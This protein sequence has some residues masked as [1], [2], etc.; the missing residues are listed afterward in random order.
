MSESL[1]GE[2][3]ALRKEIKDKFQF[4]KIKLNQRELELS[5]RVDE[6]E[7]D[8]KVRSQRILSDLDKLQRTQKVLQDTLDTEDLAGTQEATLSLISDKIGLLESSY[9][10]LQG[11]LSLTI[12][13]QSVEVLVAELGAISRGD[14]H[15][16]ASLR[17]TTRVPLRSH[18]PDP[19]SSSDTF[20][21]PSRPSRLST[22][23]S[24][25]RSDPLYSGTDPLPPSDTNLPPRR[26]PRVPSESGHGYSS[27]QPVKKSANIISKIGKWK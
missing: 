5:R 2:F 23:E 3:S 10:Q 16:T 1:S 15:E 18:T 25:L 14:T 26:V 6:M 27:P 4:V 17:H 9:S 20:T 19:F 7:T 11:H 13:T 22:H 8:F 12:D 24:F 21:Y